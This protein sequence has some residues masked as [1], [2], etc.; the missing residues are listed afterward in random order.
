MDNEIKEKLEWLAQF[1]VD[2]FL[3]SDRVQKYTLSLADRAVLMAIAN[4]IRDQDECFT[5]QLYLADYLG[6]SL[7]TIKRSIK[8]LTTSDPK[9]QLLKTYKKPSK[10]KRYKTGRHNFYALNLSNVIGCSQHLITKRKGAHSPVSQCDRVHT[11]LRKGAHSTPNITIREQVKEKRGEALS[12]FEPKEQHHRL[13]VELKLNMGEE[14][15]SFKN[16]H[17][18][19]V[20]DYEFERWLKQSYQYH[21][22]NKSVAIVPNYTEHFIKPPDGERVQDAPEQKKP[23]IPLRERVRLDREGLL[24]EPNAIISDHQRRNVSSK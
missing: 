2:D 21:R 23:Y 20:N 11:A 4:H 5:S 15:K 19:A 17:K 13:C 3:R 1:Q 14:V 16:R 22:K 18:G 9:K 7:D 12:L 10:N 8:K 6:T 24:N